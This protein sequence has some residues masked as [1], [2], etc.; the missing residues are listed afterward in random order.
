MIYPD[1]RIGGAG[2]LVYDMVDMDWVG[3][4]KRMSEASVGVWI[5]RR[6]YRSFIMA[7]VSDL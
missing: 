5:H 7:L 4:N 1:V 6:E 3:W 2:W